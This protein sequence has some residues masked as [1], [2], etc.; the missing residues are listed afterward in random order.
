MGGT[1]LALAFVLVVVNVL[2]IRVVHIYYP[3]FYSLGAVI[4]W[5]GLWMLATGQPRNGADGAKAPAWGRIGLA[6]FLVFG[7][8]AGISMI[9]T[10]WER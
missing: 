5:G 6:V 4:G 10:N 2:L 9:F 1:M 8:L 3:Y 7:V